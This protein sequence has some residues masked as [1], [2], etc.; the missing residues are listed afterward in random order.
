MKSS[1]AAAKAIV[2]GWRLLV[3]GVLGFVIIA[4]ILGR[5]K[6]QGLI[7]LALAYGLVRTGVFASTVLV[8]AR[9]LLPAFMWLEISLVLAYFGPNTY[10]FR[11]AKSDL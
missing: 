7:W 3:I 5:R 4:N 11:D 2:G 9:Y 6:D 10:G 8:E 1:P